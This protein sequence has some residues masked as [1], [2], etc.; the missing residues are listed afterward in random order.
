MFMFKMNH[1]DICSALYGI[2]PFGKC[3]DRGIP[4]TGLRSSSM[5]YLTK[6]P[7]IDS[8]TII[9]KLVYIKL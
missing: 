3:K 6:H 2:S 4:D 7:A 1:R 5:D 9:D 8:L